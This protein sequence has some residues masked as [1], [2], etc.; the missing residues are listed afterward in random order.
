[1]ERRDK[2]P[3]DGISQLKKLKLKEV[4]EKTHISIKTLNDIINSNFRSLS[5]AKTVGFL[6]ILEKEYGFNFD[7]WQSSYM[8]YVEADKEAEAR[9]ELLSDFEPKSKLPYILAFLIACVVIVYFVYPTLKYEQSNVNSDQYNI[10]ELS[11]KLNSKVD[12]NISEK[13]TTIQKVDITK[14]VVELNNT[15]DINNSLRTD[16]IKE[17][18]VQPKKEEENTTKDSKII[19]DNNII[20]ESE[21]MA[22][23]DFVYI[24]RIPLDSNSIV[25][26]TGNKIWMGMTQLGKKKDFLVDKRLNLSL[27]N[28]TIFFTGHGFFTIHNQDEQHKYREQSKK[29]FYFNDNSLYEISRKEFNNFDKENLW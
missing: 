4:S 2:K 22:L 18:I 29:Y 16:T 21:S 12:T 7:E 8:R 14:S 3:L 11:K 10:K 24:K 25:V 5:P 17:E 27:E 28:G 13:N 20:E 26:T 15:V 23:G 6:R 9:R 1:V 19:E